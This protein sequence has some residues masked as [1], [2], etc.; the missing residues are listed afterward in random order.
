[1]FARTVILNDKKF[2]LARFEDKL[3]C[4]KRGGS[5]YLEAQ[6]PDPNSGM[7]PGVLVPC[8]N[9]TSIQNTYCYH[10]RQERRNVCPITSVNFQRV[11][12]PVIEDS[13]VIEWSSQLELV[14]SRD[15]D[16][17]PISE[18][19]VEELQPCLS[20]DLVR[21]SSLEMVVKGFEQTQFVEECPVDDRWQELAGFSIS[22][23][24]LSSSSGLID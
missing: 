4:G 12:S 2:N 6:Q 16:H 8:S 21:T 11:G 18:T 3:I 1:M 10:P 15:M 7:C 23:Y 13:I 9:K 20:K 24:T 17:G 22:E 14:F 19:R 5:N